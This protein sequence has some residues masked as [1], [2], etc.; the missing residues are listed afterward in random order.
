MAFVSLV[1]A[2]MVV[3]CSAYAFGAASPGPSNLAIMATAM[4]G[5]RRRALVFALG[6]VSGSAIWGA[7]T[8]FGV[9]AALV[10]APSILVAMKTAGGVY[11]LWLSFKALRRA[12]AGDVPGAAAAGSDAHAGSALALYCRGA[13]LHL[14]NPKAILVW[15]SIIAL[16][17]DGDAGV[18]AGLPVVAACLAIG[19]IIFLGY[20]VVFSTAV[21]R[22]LYVRARRWFDAVVGLA[23]GAAGVGM[24]AG[25]TLA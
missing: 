20:A 6:V 25:L 4:Q 8:A 7:L 2:N 17:L 22:R 15:L 12:L 10:K 3:A 24:L 23:F 5:G 16:A 21:A 9:A 11:L 13:A 14:T 19:A 18:S 1:S